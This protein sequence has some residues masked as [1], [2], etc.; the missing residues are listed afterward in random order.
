MFI[1]TS[2]KFVLR[3]ARKT[4]DTGLEGREYL[5]G[6]GKGTYTIA[7]IAN[8]CWVFCHEWAGAIAVATLMM[9][10]FATHIG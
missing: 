9:S 8:F 10:C 1:F 4:L 6:P 3:M 5:A 2:A 7:D